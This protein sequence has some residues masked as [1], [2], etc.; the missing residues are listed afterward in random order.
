[1][2]VPPFLWDWF[3]CPPT[4]TSPNTPIP[5]LWFLLTLCSFCVL[6]PSTFPAY[7]CVHLFQGFGTMSESNS[8]WL[9]FLSPHTSQHS[10][11][12]F[13]FS[14]ANLFHLF[15]IGILQLKLKQFPIRAFLKI[16]NP[17]T[18]KRKEW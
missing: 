5:V 13:F 7:C 2:G 12:N 17:M 18:L 6:L 9:I 10:N 1:M 11:V 16:N 4:P 3:Y 8:V 14:Y 15:Q